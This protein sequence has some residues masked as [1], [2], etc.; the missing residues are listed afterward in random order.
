[1][2]KN[3]LLFL[4]L[5]FIT[6]ISAQPFGDLIKK[7]GN[8]KSYPNYDQ[9]V[10][11]DS[12]LVDMQET[13]LTYVVNHTLTKVLNNHGAV[14]L[15][16][17]KYGYDPLSA[18]VE[19]RKA[20]IYKNDG[21]II[22]LDVQKAMDYP[23]PARAI[24]WGAREKML[25]IGKLE[26]GDA[27]EMI[28][29][30]KGFTY[31][32]LAADDD[33]KY[34]PP[35]KG[36]FYDIVEFFGSNPIKSKVYRVTV[37][38]DKPLQYQFYNGEAQSSCW[39]EG[40]KIVYTFSK[41]DILPL[42]TEPRMVAMVDVA[43]KLLVS[44]TDG[45]NQKSTWFY[46]VNEDFGSFTPDREIKDKVNEI[47]R[48]ATNE[49]DSVARLTHWCA[50]EVRYSGIS[51]GCGEGFTLHKGSMTFAD[52][53]GVCKDKAG[54]LITML[55]AAGFQS[56][57]AMTMAGSRIDYIP[58]DQFNHCVTV[59]KLRDGKY[60]LLDPTWVPFVRELWSSAEQQQ[61]Y[62][63]GVPEG[64]DLATTPVSNPE[65]HYVKIDGVARLQANGTLAGRIT[66]T[67]EG[68][69]DAAIR[70]L[71]KYS[72]RTTWYQNIEREL[73]RVWPQ[74]KITQVKY[75]DPADYLNYNIWVA[76]DY[77]IPEFALVSGNKLMFTPLSAGGI[78]RQFQ[79]QLSFETGTKERKYSFRDRCS[80]KVEINETIT[81]PENNKITR[82]PETV[83][84][85]GEIVSYRGNYSHANGAVIFS[86]T[87]VF[88]KRQYE[89]QDWPEFKAAVEAQNKFAEQPVI[90]E[91]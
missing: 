79:G 58:A 45:W 64:A 65:N 43:P 38:K 62:L 31:A 29:F 6:G 69:S 16:I 33:D 23:A 8:A 39:F 9:L 87:S 17:V 90:I 49:M 74:A 12:T 34:I 46:K 41:K 76:I 25:E 77:S 83:E 1:M 86:G 56:Y 72:G 40:G 91:L 14:D 51:M 35:M 5:V 84:K 52:R 42:K 30:R 55:R 26:P 18:F 57:P 54:M 20:V 48:G 44:T 27:I 3:L 60:H 73:L 15:G 10:I 68:Q 32:L 24:Y 71:F 75:T 85:S 47:L 82:I 13:G 89:P 19:I 28:M 67:G 37:P 36:Q 53:C 21:Q 80:R 2:K 50:D 22:E 78:F 7:A 70:G 4:Q 81:L 11:F 88:G 63:M 59:V 61:Q 66:I